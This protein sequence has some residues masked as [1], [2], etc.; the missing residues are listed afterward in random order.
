M[1]RSIALVAVAAAAIPAPAARR[2]Y[3]SAAAQATRSAFSARGLV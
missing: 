1:H 3:G 2:L